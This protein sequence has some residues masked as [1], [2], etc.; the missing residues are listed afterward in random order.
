MSTDT[1]A[2]TG[3]AARAH[4]GH[5]RPRGAQASP[6][7][8]PTFIFADLVGYTALT[9]ERGDRAALAL[10]RSF[11]RLMHRL[12][13]AHG[14]W[15][16]K[17]MGDGV[18]IWA[19]E[20]ER[21]VALAAETVAKVAEHD[22]LPPVRVGVHTGQAVMSAGDWFGRAVNFA[23]RLARHARPGEAL[24][25]AATQAAAGHELARRNAVPCEVRIPDHDGPVPAW[26][27]RH[28]L[29]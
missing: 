15:Q 25:S 21:A 24:V 17:S 6:R 26:R 1:L 28:H 5:A 14:A 2:H 4:G 29:I 27:L 7:P 22:E 9:E 3:L 18:M 10:A 11:H 12:S 20:P 23:A 8:V 13:R 16:V 19:P